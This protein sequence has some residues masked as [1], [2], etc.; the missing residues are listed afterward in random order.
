[1]NKKLRR[2]HIF[3]ANLDPTIGVEIK[4]LRPVIIMSNN[5]INQRSRLVIVVPITTNIK[6]FSPSHVLIPKGESGL[7]KTSKALAEQIRAIDKQRLVNYAG[8]VSPRV[9]KLVEQA[10][11]NSLDM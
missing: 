3:W 5:V 6:H 9:L 8:N 11:Q 2:G 4:K 7:A 10:I 1:M